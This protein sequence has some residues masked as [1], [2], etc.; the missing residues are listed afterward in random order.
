I[1]SPYM[2]DHTVT[3][4]IVSATGRNNL[5]L[6]GRDENSYQ[7]FIQ[8]DAAINP[9]NS[10]GPLID[11]AGKVI[12]INTAI[13]TGA[14]FRG[15]EGGAQSG[16]FEGIGL[17]IPSSMA[18]R[19]AEDLIKNGK[20]IRGFLGVMIRTA[21]PD[22]AKQ[23]N[24]PDARGVLITGVQAGSPADKAGLQPGDI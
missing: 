12:G 5:P 1:G 4:G 21:T 20:V 10:G 11:L 13:L 2:L 22:L 14:S 8:T 24:S 23:F 18:R 3:A 15:G 9:G 6:P 7:D 19:V 16:G 17:A